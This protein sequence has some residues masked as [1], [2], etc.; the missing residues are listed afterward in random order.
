MVDNKLTITIVHPMNTTRKILEYLEN[1]TGAT[2]SQLAAMLNVSRQAVNKQLKPLV[3]SGIVIKEGDTRGT[4]YRMYRGKRT[5]SVAKRLKKKLKPEEIDSEKLFDE[6]A[7]FFNFNHLLTDNS[8]QLSRISFFEIIGNVVRHSGTAVCTVEWLLDPYNLQIRIR[9]LGRGIFQAIAEKKSFSEENEALTEVMK[10]GTESL[11]QLDT[12]RGI[13]YA[14]KA[15][16]LISFRSHRTKIT[17]DNLKP[18]VVVEE[19]KFQEGTDV[20][21][22]VGRRSRKSLAGFP[23]FHP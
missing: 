8:R 2:G 13:H 4:I 19:L 9:D 16:D 6:A 5:S 17:F 21:I 23:G 7:L 14:T 12:S 10:F 20:F 3:Q 1:N 11:E 18:D 15:A 22:Q